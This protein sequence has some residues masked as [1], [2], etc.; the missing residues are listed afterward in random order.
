MH[1]KVAVSDNDVCKLEAFKFLVFG[2]IGLTQSLVE[3]SSCCEVADII[4]GFKRLNSEVKSNCSL[5][6]TL[7]ECQPH[8]A[9]ISLK[10]NGLFVIL[11][12][13]A[14]TCL[15]ISSNT[16]SVKSSCAFSWVDTVCESCFLSRVNSYTLN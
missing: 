5:F 13:L 10:Y 8:L 16:V 3:G 11:S 15:K 9:Q 7:C 6:E 2:E 4:N 1:G 14:L 12:S